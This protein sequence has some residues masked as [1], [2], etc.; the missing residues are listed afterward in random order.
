MKDL[1][2][3]KERKIQILLKT[4]PIKHLLRLKYSVR[5]RKKKPLIRCDAT[6]V[7]LIFFTSTFTCNYLKSSGFFVW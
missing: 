4:I 5:G 3:L 2:S 1:F 7:A 6:W